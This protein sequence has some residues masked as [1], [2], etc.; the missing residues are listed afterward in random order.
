MLQEGVNEGIFSFSESCEEKAFF[1]ASATEGAMIFA[2]AFDRK[3]HYESTVEQIKKT[4][5]S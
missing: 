1:I 2:R 4:I 3:D 5:L